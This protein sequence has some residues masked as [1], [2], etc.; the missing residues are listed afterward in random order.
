MATRPQF[1][2]E[3][4]AWMEQESSRAAELFWDSS[5][6]RVVLPLGLSG[7][8]DSTGANVDWGAA[9]EGVARRTVERELTNV[10]GNLLGGPGFGRGALRQ[11]HLSGKS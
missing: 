1:S 6:S 9:V 7:P 10:L 3:V 11:I 4:S 2:P 5:S 8:L